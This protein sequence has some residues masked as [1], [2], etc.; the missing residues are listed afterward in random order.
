MA[1][2]NQQNQENKEIPAVYRTFMGAK[3]LWPPECP[4]DVLEGAIKETQNTIGRT[5]NLSKEGQK[6]AEHLKKYMDDNFEPYWHVFFGKN[7]GSYTVH[8]KNRFIYFYFKDMAFLMYQS[9]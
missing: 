5:E 9:Q 8:N 4:D 7:F 6:I 1:T 2:N 3:V